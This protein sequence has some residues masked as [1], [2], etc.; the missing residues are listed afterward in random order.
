VISSLGDGHRGQAFEDLFRAADVDLGYFSLVLMSGPLA[1]ATP[2][3]ATCQD[4]SAR[5]H[6]P[7]TSAYPPARFGSRSPIFPLRGGLQGEDR[8]PAGDVEALYTLDAQR[9]K[10]HGLLGATYKCVGT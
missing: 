8:D 2:L 1:A 10:H 6:A 3:S 7:W 4:L 5:Q 9:L